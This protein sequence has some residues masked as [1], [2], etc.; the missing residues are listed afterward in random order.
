MSTE[1]AAKE[2]QPSVQASWE[3]LTKRRL[4]LTVAGLQCALFLAALDQTIVST[5]MPRIVADLNGFEHYAWATTAYMLSSTAVV[6]I[7]A[8]LSDMYG[9]KRFLLGGALS[10]VLASLLCS[11][12]QDMTQL[13]LLR[14]LQGIGGGALMASIFTT[15]SLLFSPAQRG[16]VLGLFSSI[17]GLAS[18]VGPLMGGF[19]TDSFGW[20]WIFLVNVPV[21]AATLI[22]LWLAFPD[23]RLSSNKHRID[24]LGAF[25][26]VV[27]VV[28][29]LLAL[30]WGGQEY[31][32]SSPQILGMFAFSFV[33]LTAFVFTERR[34]DEPIIPLRMLHNRTIVAALISLVCLAMGMFGTILYVPL[35]LQAVVGLS[36]TESGTALI[37]MMLSLVLV[38]IISGQLIS[39]SGHYK[40]IGVL[41]LGVASVG[42]LLL[43]GMGP[44]TGYTTAV[45]NMMVVGAGL[46]LAMPVHVLAAQNCV[47]VS[48]IGVVTGLTQ[49]FRSIGGTAGA[50]IMGSVLINRFAPAFHVALPEQTQA[51]LSPAILTELE[52]PQV[53]LHPRAA[54][55]IRQ[56]LTAVDAPGID[57]FSQVIESVRVGLTGALHDVFLAAAIVLALGALATLVIQEVEL[58]KTHDFTPRPSD[59]KVT[60]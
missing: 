57:L 36:A 28:P 52:N 33:M 56:A 26:L 53:L 34:A 31:A 22:V 8:K 38:S 42:L 21:G 19:L 23:I 55:Q 47:H 60:G 10:F 7:V 13:A 54:E 11:L 59:Q 14:G 44:D 5:A 49:F 20:R 17:Y 51:L 35:Y 37:P 1:A 48:E 32:W 40:W 29:L 43:S 41:G 9:R 16:K 58:R 39:R 18:V 45:R 12:A 2:P 25:L 24:F 46:G 15:I 27:G 50:A 3:G 4:Y 30:S 6:P